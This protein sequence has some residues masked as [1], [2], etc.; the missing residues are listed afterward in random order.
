MGDEGACIAVGHLQRHTQQHGEDEEEGH[1]LFAEEAEGVQSQHLRERTARFALDKRAGGKREAI[2][3][4]QDAEQSADSELHVGVLELAG[5]VS[6]GETEGTVRQASAI[7]KPHRG[8]EAHCAKYADGREVRDGVQPVI[9]EDGEGRRIGEGQRGH[10]ESH[11]H[12]VDGDEQGRVGGGRG[13]AEVGKA[14]HHAACHQV[15]DAEQLL[16]LDKLIGN[17]SHECRHKDGDDALDGIEPG[18]LGDHA[19][20]NQIVAH[21]GQI[22]APNCKLQEI[23]NDEA[24]LE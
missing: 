1:A 23:H 19:G 9:L 10:I 3:E 6:Q 18:N 5:L 12:R 8:D 7:H 16:R 11:A 20:T 13:A 15:A 2:E 4:Q 24:R 22:G 21:R 17:D 14:Q